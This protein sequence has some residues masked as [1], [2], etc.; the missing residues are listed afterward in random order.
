[1]NGQRIDRKDIWCGENRDPGV[2][3]ASLNLDATECGLDPLNAKTQTHHGKPERGCAI[4]SF[5]PQ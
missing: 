4:S 3:F 2:T 5:I 1:M